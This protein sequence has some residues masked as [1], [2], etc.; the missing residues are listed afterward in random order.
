MIS[1]DTATLSAQDNYKLLTGSI[2]PRPIAWVT[3]LS[4]SGVLNAAP[5]SYFS[6]IASTPPLI[7]VSIQRKQ[8]V[9]KDTASNALAA[10]AFV[11]HVVDESNVGAANCTAAPLPPEESEVSLAGLTP[12]ASEA[13][14]VP[15]ILEAKIRMEC[16][17]EQTFPLGDD[18]SGPTCD[19]L[20]GRVV[21]YHLASDV[22]Q[23]G[24]ILAEQLRPVSRLAG[25]A[26]ASLGQIFHM[27]RPGE[28]TR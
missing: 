9:M 18:G 13:V 25:R 16:V 8:G 1:I 6:I 21:R 26:Y 15:G 7:S 5:F 19:L 11:V 10:E 27:E 3:T 22:Y 20:I 2:I 23:D 24:Y 14:V 28:P 17:L 4:E 12:V